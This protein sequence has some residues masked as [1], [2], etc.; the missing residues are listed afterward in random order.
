MPRSCQNSANTLTYY[1]AFHAVVFTV[2]N[3]A[4]CHSW[5]FVLLILMHNKLEYN[6]LYIKLVCQFLRYQS[7]WYLKYLK[8]KALVFSDCS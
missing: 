7:L 8:Q 4:I 1:V 6:Q 2:Y 3:H 5:A